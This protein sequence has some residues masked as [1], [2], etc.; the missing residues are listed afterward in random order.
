MMEGN[1]SIYT[2][3][4][5]NNRIELPV[6]DDVVPEENDAPQ[7]IEPYQSD[8]IHLPPGDELALFGVHRFE[9]SIE[10]LHAALGHETRVQLQDLRFEEVFVHLRVQIG[11]FAHQLREPLEARLP[12]GDE[13]RP[14]D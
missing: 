14:L 8:V 11:L 13:Y 10:A 4:R 2:H 3:E 1:K 9:E 5:T 7:I 12:V 6:G